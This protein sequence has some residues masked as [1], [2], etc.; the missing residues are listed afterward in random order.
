MAAIHLPERTVRS[1]R[2]ETNELNDE[3]A[4][5][6]AGSRLRLPL[7]AERLVERPVGNLPRGVG[8]LPLPDEQ[9]ACPR[10]LRREADECTYLRH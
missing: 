9:V 3:V 5:A 1:I 7:L 6:D 10:V 4:L 2:L 8:V